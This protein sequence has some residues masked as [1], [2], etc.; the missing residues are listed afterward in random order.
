MNRLFDDLDDRMESD[1]TPPKCSCCGVIADDVYPLTDN[2][3]IEYCLDCAKNHGYELCDHCEK[4]CPQ[5]YFVGDDEP[6]CVD[7]YS[8]RI[9]A[10]HEYLKDLD[11]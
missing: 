7:C 2:D 8:S 1:P 6:L 3:S 9:D 10:A 11:F 4:L 5:D